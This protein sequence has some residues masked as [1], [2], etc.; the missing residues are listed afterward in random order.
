MVMPS[1]GPLNM[2]GTSSP[3]SVAQEL[4]LSLTATITMNDAAVRTLA[5]VGGTGTTW[6]MSSLYG[7]SNSAYFLALYGPQSSTNLYFGVGSGVDSSGNIYALVNGSVSGNTPYA[8]T[9]MAKLDASGGFLWQNTFTTTDLPNREGYAAGVFGADGNVHGIL[10]TGNNNRTVVTAVSSAGSLLSS[11][12]LTCVNPGSI[13]TVQDLCVD[14]SGNRYL[15]AY[16]FNSNTSVFSGVF[17]KMDSAGTIQFQLAAVASSGNRITHLSIDGSNSLYT[18]TPFFDGSLYRLYV[19]KFNSSGAAQYTRIL[20]PPASNQFYA[21]SSSTAVDSSGNIYVCSTI[22]NINTGVGAPVLVKLD[23][24][25]SVLWSRSLGGG[26]S[27]RS[28]IALGPDGNVYVA[29]RPENAPRFRVYKYNAS[30]TVQWIRSL[31]GASASN[32]PGVQYDF[33]LSVGADYFS[34]TCVAA[35][36]SSYSNA[37]IAR[38]P[39]DGS[40]TGTY[41]VGAVNVT[42]A[43][44]T[45]DA[46][47]TITSTSGSSLFSSATLLSSSVANGSIATTTTTTNRTIV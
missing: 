27:G 2:G 21:Y 10:V 3:V 23:S 41:A 29:T 30:G 40:K 28:K 34:V 18:A 5:G 1:S 4:G 37:L 46:A 38:L 16:V 24:S 39:L 45:G 31:V 25:G 26:L 43:S 44:A 6:S 14:S 8:V 42:Y 36:S 32:Y 15:T 7:K 17:L 35:P 11:R 47:V 9:G 20:S 22:Q 12:L 19:S 13:N 33:G